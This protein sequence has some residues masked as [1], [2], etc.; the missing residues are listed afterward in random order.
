MRRSSDRCCQKKGVGENGRKESSLETMEEGGK[1]KKFVKLASPKVAF[2]EQ[3][4]ILISCTY[5]HI[6]RVYY[7]RLSR[8]Q[9]AGRAA[10]LSPSRRRGSF[11][12]N[13]WCSSGQRARQERGGRE[14]GEGRERNE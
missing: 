4:K 9:F 1:E 13:C 7:V 3:H 11:D 8:M 2:G 6:G 12:A 14:R 10:H 5:I